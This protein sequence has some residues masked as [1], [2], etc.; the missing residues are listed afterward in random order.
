MAK[1]SEFDK[2]IIRRVKEKR[3]KEGISLRTIAAIIGVHH[4]FPQKVEKDDLLCKYSTEHLYYI[5]QYFECPI[6]E[7]YPDS[8]QFP[9]KIE[10]SNR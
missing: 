7:F 8:N 10:L 5:A 2:E 9:P 1:K 6:T 3:L 4:S